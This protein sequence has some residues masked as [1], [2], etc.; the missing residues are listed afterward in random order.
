M[1]TKWDRTPLRVRL[2]ASVLVLVAGALILISIAAL[3]ALHTYFLST[4]DAELEDRLDQLKLEEIDQSTQAESNIRPNQYYFIVQYAEGS[5]FI[6]P[7]NRENA[8]S[9]TYD[10]LVDA[11]GEAFNAL[12]EDGS[13]RWRVMGM[14]V[15]TAETDTGGDGPTHYVMAYKLEHFDQSVAGLVWVIILVGTGVLA[16]LATLGAGLV[17]A[18][19]SPLRHIETTAAIIAAG[20]YSRRIPDRDPQTEMGRVG[21]AINSMLK[22]IEVSIRGRERSEDRALRSEQRMREFI[23]DASHELRTPL[24][25][26]R[27]YA[28]L[29]RTNPMMPE[30]DR[31]YYVGQI[32]EAAKR[33]GLLVS[34][35][36]LLAR[37]D[38]ERPIEL[39]P[40]EITG[41]LSDAVSAAQVSGSDR[42]FV[43]EGPDSEITVAGDRSRL[44]QIF[45]NLLNNAVQHTPPGTRVVVSLELRDDTV[46]IEV[47]DNGP[48]MEREDRDRVFERFYRSS[49]P[50]TLPGQSGG[51]GLGLAI[52][53]AIVQA[54][55]GEVDVDSRPGEG[56]TFTVILRRTRREDSSD[57]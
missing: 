49:G 23:A 16:G 17:R 51:H 5:Q 37:L 54:H 20:D 10:D 6:R 48:G 30:S 25:S 29:V 31:L 3:V 39:M 7:D 21:V 57:S 44:R 1:G 32:E 56:T 55:R 33:M 24:T 9:F 4:V 41:V 35:L 15:D 43:Y 28:E 19:L 53:A 47:A 11:D 34:D 13:V 52:V 45:D 8:P 12:A 18:S 27:G 14:P 26:V 50:I 40:V 38:Q 2:T 36:L 42:E 22:K 46:A